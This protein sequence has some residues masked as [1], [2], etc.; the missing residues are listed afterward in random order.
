MKGWDSYEVYLAF[1]CNFCHFLYI[2]LL[3]NDM[4]PGILSFVFFFQIF[5]FVLPLLVIYH[6]TYLCLHIYCGSLNES[7][8]SS[9]SH[10]RLRRM[11]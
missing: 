11:T 10:L 6:L 7:K 9:E 1:E 8:S 3:L 4:H 2:S 5:S